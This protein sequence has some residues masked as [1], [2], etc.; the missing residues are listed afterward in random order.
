MK[1]RWL[2]V[3]LVALIGCG[4]KQE[5]EGG[6]PASGGPSAFKTWMPADAAKQWEGAWAGRMT[7]LQSNKKKYTSMAGDPVAIEIKGSE[8]TVWDGN[9]ETPMKFSLRSPCEARF[10]EAITEGS[11]KGGTSYHDMNFVIENGQLVIGSGDVGFR[12]GKA[13][14]VCTSGMDGGVT[15]L[16][17]AG[18]CTAWTDD[19][20]KWEKKSVTCTWSK[21]GDKDTLVLDGARGKTTLVADGDVLVGDQFRDHT[22]YYKRAKDFADAKAQTQAE[23]DANDPAKQA[24]AAGGVVG[25]TDT[26]LSLIATFGSDPSLAGKSHEITALYLNENRM[27]SNGETTYNVILVDSRESTKLS[28]TC[29][30]GATAPPEGLVQYDKVVAKGTIGEAFGKPE[31]TGCTVTKAP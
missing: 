2:A 6:K 25:Q 18:A 31:L 28:L 30:L 13:A 21:D 16:D 20:G 3:G 8:A 15:I 12:K 10:A 17:D 29:N 5:G 27:T 1:R 26:V 24:Q 14:V 22:K 7:S 19:F 4:N 11:M 23:L 9:A